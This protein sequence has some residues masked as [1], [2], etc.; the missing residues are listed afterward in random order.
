MLSGLLFRGMLWYR[1]FF[2]LGLLCFVEEEIDSVST[3]MDMTPGLEVSM[4]QE[5]SERVLEM[6]WV[7]REASACLTDAV[8]IPTY[9]IAQA[10]YIA[11]MF[12]I[13]A[14]WTVLASNCM[15]QSC[16][17]LQC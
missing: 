3:G 8:N 11:L 15:Y 2:C 14:K 12:L 10:A 4:R 7:R 1:K 6:L 5:G 13:N 17:V 9:P 16:V